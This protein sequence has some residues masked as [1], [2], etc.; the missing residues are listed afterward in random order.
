MYVGGTHNYV[1]TVTPGCLRRETCFTCF[2][3]D[4]KATLLIGKGGNYVDKK[5]THVDRKATHVDRRAI[6]VCGTG[7]RY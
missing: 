3:I 1:C 4:G 5:G 6:Q 2:V 7:V